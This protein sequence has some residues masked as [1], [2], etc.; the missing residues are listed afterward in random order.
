MDECMQ[1]IY[2]LQESMREWEPMTEYEYVCESLTDPVIAAK[3][4]KNQKVA[5]KSGNA[6]QR[7]INAV[8]MMIKKLKA[9][10]NDFFER[11][12]MGK[13]EKAMFDEYRRQIAENPNLKNKK[14]TV[15]DFRAIQKAYDEKL[16]Q[17]DAEIRKV[18]ADETHPIDDV[19]NEI[20]GF[21]SGTVKATGTIVVADTAVKIAESNVKAARAIN[22]ALNMNDDFL[23]SL[24]AECGEKDA[25]KFKKRVNA[26]A[27]NTVL[28]RLKIKILHREYDYLSDCA[29]STLDS[30]KK[31]GFL[32][33]M[34]KMGRQ[35]RKNQYTGKVIKTAQDSVIKAGKEELRRA[36]GQE[37]DKRLHPKKHEKMKNR[38]GEYKSLSSFVMGDKDERKRR[39]K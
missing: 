34:T 32:N 14:F 6:L 23:K 17:V 18:K 19:V 26:A 27:K 9:T 11:M 36:A 30:L 4:E 33:P 1:N 10:I 21:L 24:A 8:V 29:G 3:A 13:D 31:G 5:N 15:K 7:A 37:L 16:A 38:E 22:R 20:T 35:F 28:T 25:M 2:I 12:K 39:R